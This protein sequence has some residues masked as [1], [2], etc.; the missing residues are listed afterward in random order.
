MK[1]RPPPNRAASTP[2][3]GDQLPAARLTPMMTQYWEVKKAHREAI[4][5]FRMGDFYETFYDDAKIAARVLGLTLTTRDRQ[6]DNPVPLAGVPFHSADA[7]VSRLLRAGYKVA[8]CEQMEDPAL[9][10]GLVRRAVTEVLTPGTAL[11]PALLPERDSHYALC[12]ALQG[13]EAADAPFGFACLDFSTGEFALGERPAREV[14]DVVARYAPREIFLPRAA[15]ASPPEREMHRR[16]EGVTISFL[17]DA[18]FTPRIATEALT[19]HFGVLSLDGLGCAEFPAGVAAA[20][21]LL[22]CGMRLKQGRLAAVT[23]LQVVRETEEL[24]L[25]DETLANLEIFRPLRGQDPGVTLVHHL[26]EC[27][28]AMGSRLLRAWIAAPRRDPSVAGARHAAVAWLIEHS[29]EMETLREQLAG[30]GDLERLMGRIAA[31]RATPRDVVGFAEACER[32]PGIAAPVAPASA[33]L[34]S[35]LHAAVDPLADLARDVRATVV[36]DPPPHL[37]EGGVIRPGA[38]AALDALLDSTREAREWI[39]GLQ[40]SE[41]RAT[42]IAK[43]KVGYNKVFGYYLEVPRGQAERV[44]AHYTGK[45]TLVGAQRYITPELKEREQLVLRAEAERTR[46]ELSLFNELRTRLAAEAERVQATAAAV[47][48]LDVLAAFAFVARKR[49]YCRPELTRG[50]RIRIHGGRHPVVER[51]LESEFVPND[52]ELSTSEAQILLITGPNMG[53]KSTFLRQVAL[54]VLMAYAGSY[55]PAR[56]AEIG[57]V[58]RIFTRVGASDNLARG[59]STFLVEMTETAKILNCAT[60]QSLVVLDEV[61][62]GTSTHDGMSLAWAVVE[63]LHDLGP[64]RPRTLFATHYHE[65]TVLEETL[66]R[67]R[68]LTVEVKEWQDEMLFLHRIR[69]GRAD[70]SYGVQVAKLAGLPPEVI[71]RAREVLSGHERMEEALAHGGRPPRPEPRQMDL[72]GATERQVADTLRGTSVDGLTADEALALLVRLRALL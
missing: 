59:Q 62:R 10:K 70:K 26:D 13:D 67:L 20:G 72:F 44:P 3:G 63:Y 61:G 5:L 36:D 9:A 34:L 65:L 4:V 53:G 29:R 45:Q 58:D 54:I 22:D 31:D 57:V 8:I 49:D 55:V 38:A 51:L 19:R 21:A 17:E 48:A 46:L 35:E 7:Y 42:G 25:D 27:R 14:F 12:L 33:G 43:L 64:A 60:S 11:V 47:A 18:S 56:A 2:S 16:F 41:R 28:T 39:A 30:M 23:R 66:S 69:P 40:A 52:V 50:D 1:R 24:V 15:L 32:L 6:S 68:N 37:R 71:Q